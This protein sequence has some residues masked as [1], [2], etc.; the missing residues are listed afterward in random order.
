M[1]QDTGFSLAEL[2]KYTND[3]LRQAL[4]QKGP[5]DTLIVFTGC[6]LELSVT[7][8]AEGG[9]GLKFWV[10][11]ASGKM[12]NE[13]VSKIKLSFSPPSS[14]PPVLVSDATETR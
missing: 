5:D 2:V 4:L 14:K 1:P 13:T 6:E 3:E 9:G 11:D 8:K 10:V 7:V 12:A